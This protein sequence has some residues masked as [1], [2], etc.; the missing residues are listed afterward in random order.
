M[1][2]QELGIF[3]REDVVCDDA[4]TVVVAERLAERQQQRSLPAANRSADPDGEAA[5]GVVAGERR[6]TLMEQ[7][8]MGGVLMVVGDVV[9]VWISLGSDSS[10]RLKETRIQTIVAGLPQIDQRRRLRDVI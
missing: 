4:E 7:A 1:P 9:H 5:H 8:R 2:D 6:P 10:L 3:A